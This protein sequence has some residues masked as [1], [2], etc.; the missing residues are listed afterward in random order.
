MKKL[1]ILCTYL[2]L[3][4]FTSGNLFS[5][6]A[7][8]I[9][10]DFDRK[11]GEID[12]NI[13]GGFLEP[14]RTVVYG[15][16]YDPFSPL[17][18][19]NGFRRDYMELIRELKVPV[20]RWPGGNYVSGYN[21][22]DGIGPKDQRP[23][24]LDLAW[25]QIENNQMGTDEYVRFC[26]LVGAENF[27]CINAGTGSLDDARHWAEYCNYEKGTY[28]SDL[29]R[30][31]GHEEPFKVKYWALGNEIDGPWQMGQKSVEDYV[32][33]AGEA[34]KL[35]RLVDRDVKLIAC[36]ASDYRPEDNRWIDWNDYVLNQ[37]VGTI[38]YISVHRYVT[39]ALKGDRGF[40]S[41]VS[42]SLDLDQK[43]ETVE[44]LILKAMMKSESERPVYI[45]LD[46]WGARG[47]G[48]LGSLIVALHMNSFIRHA[49]IVKMANM[50]MLTSLVGISPDGDF[51]N[52]LFQAFYLYSNHCHGT[53]L[54][55]STKC[56]TYSN[57]I[58][59]DIP[60][61]DVSAVLNEPDQMLI[62]NVVNRHETDAIETDVVLQTGDFTGTGKVYEVNGETIE[63]T[64]TKTEQGVSIETK[65]I[66]FKGNTI[67]YSFPAHSL[68]QIE[69]PV[70]EL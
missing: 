47:R 66:K 25:H 51:R 26:N 40:S 16:L 48:L 36:G 24:R 55:V 58:F 65:E 9:K 45:S 35:I 20:I 15:T 62:V 5:Q 2:I 52:T 41:M 11:I 49:D 50:T 29:R 69:I 4:G 64:N 42:L 56:E 61:L 23:A 3:A 19:E 21:W 1:R 38:D 70:R 28:Y 44:A 13:Y 63:A 7:A 12:P 43:I 22:E 31:Y 59:N 60:Y 39:E 67:R 27:I 37:M 34:A 46:E 32:K 6:E 18:D 14:I 53:S 54:D 10:I 30:K 8:V 57:E 33:F 68:T 17:A